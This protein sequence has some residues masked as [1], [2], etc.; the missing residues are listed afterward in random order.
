MKIR[1]P[2]LSVVIPIFNEED[3]ISELSGRLKKVMTEM[4]HTYEIIFIDD[5]STDRSLAMLKQCQEETPEITIIEFNRNYGQHAAVFAGFE[6]SSGEI[7]VTL[8]ADL[9]NPPEEIPKLVNKAEEGFEVVATVR[10]KRKDS[11]FRKCASYTINRITAK[12]TGVKLKDYGCMLRVYRKN[13]VTLMCAS[14]EI[15]TFIPVLATSYARNMAEIEV[16]HDSRNQGDSKYSIMRL[17]SL[18]F[19]LMTSFSIWPLRML[20]FLGLA[21]S[22][23]GV[24]FGIY[25]FAMRIIMGAE[26]AVG[27]VFTLF[28]V[29]FFFVGTQFLAFGLLGEYIGRIYAE[30]RK[31]PRFVIEKIYSHEE[32][33]CY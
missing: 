28:A 23:A 1:A 21:V 10:V 33:I 4:D 9:Q 31:R 14:K 25:L 18:Q 32:E 26:W 19:D 3:N 11:L 2:Y 30:V 7:V 13:I 12:I 15:S 8:D 6:R 17:I 24:G 27:G 22:L 20:M 16:K 5:G 29:L